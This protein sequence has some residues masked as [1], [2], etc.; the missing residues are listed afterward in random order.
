MSVLS[1]LSVLVTG[2]SRGIGRAVVEALTAGGA[3]VAFTYR[4]DATAARAVE[5]AT[6]A[7]AFPLDLADRRRPDDL[8][9]EVEAALGPL[10]GLVNNAAVRHQ[11][12]LALTSDADWD[13]V[14]DADLGG[15]FRC[16]R[17]ALRGM[18]HRRRGSIVNV[19]SLAALHAVAGEAAYAAAKAGVLALTRTLAREVGKKGVRVNAVV[20]GFVATEMTAGL[21]ADAVARLRGSECLP[22]GVE[23]AAVAAAV[24][25]LLS[26][27]ARAITGQAVVVDAG[28]ST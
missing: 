14:I 19:A 27:G 11:A 22:G 2:G 4:S 23:P 12:L 17:A 20:P 10:T 25:F 13:R 24:A 6:G 18:V 26:D 3:A 21:G 8:V 7:R 1:V 5:A 28:A 9:A 16:C 15:V